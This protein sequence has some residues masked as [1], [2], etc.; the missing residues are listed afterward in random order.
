MNSLFND[1]PLLIL[2]TLFASFSRCAGQVL[3]FKLYTTR[4]GLLSNGVTTLF[5]DSFGYLWIGTTDGLS[6]YNGESFRNYTVVNGLASSWVNCI[7]EDSKIRGEIWIATLGGGVSR[8]FHGTFTNFAVGSNAWTNRVNSICQGE[9]GTVYCATEQGVFELAG[10]KSSPL[11]P[12]LAARAFVQIGCRGD[13]LFL[14][15]DKGNL[16]IYNLLNGSVA[17]LTDLR[18]RR[19]GVSAFLLGS[20]NEL[21]LALMNGTIENYYRDKVM[22][23]ATGEPANFLLE[24]RDDVLW[25]GTTDGLYD[26]DERDPDNDKPQQHLR[27]VE[28]LSILRR[29]YA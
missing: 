7:I 16:S 11:S 1:F 3:P 28:A 18:I 15:D 25:V 23:H 9:D 21:W 22:P 12:K 17:G 26:L 5:Q 8:F 24:G 14:L 20:R 29:A 10:G 27:Q 6:V 13:S 19:V 4:E 2:L